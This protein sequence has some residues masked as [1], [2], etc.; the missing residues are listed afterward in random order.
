MDEKLLN[1]LETTYRDLETRQ[2]EAVALDAQGNQGETRRRVLAELNGPL[3]K[4]ADELC[5]RIAAAANEHVEENSAH[6]ARRVHQTAWVV[7]VSGGLT[8]GLGGALLWLFF[9]R[10]MIPLRGLVGDVQLLYGGAVPSQDHSEEDE[11]RMVGTCF[12]GLMSDVTDTRSSLERS[13]SRLL[14]AEKLASVGKLAASVA[15][16]IRNPLTAMKMWLFSIQESVRGNPELDHKLGIISEET[17]RL[18]HI[19]RDFLEFARPPPFAVRNSA[20]PDNPADVGTPRC[21]LKREE[22]FRGERAHGRSASR[23]G[24]PGPAQT[25]VDQRD[26]QC[27]GRDEHRR[28]D[29]HLDDGG[30]GRGGPLHGRG[31]DLRLGAGMAQAV[32]RRVFEPFFSTK[33]S[34]TGLGL[35]IA[36]RIMAAHNGL[37]VLESSSGKGTTFAI[38]TPVAQAGTH[39]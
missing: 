25:S 11:M 31:A 8:L 9:R 23:N 5:V 21:L 13:H 1:R 24:R 37:L 26:E 12:R 38:W 14:V 16:E 10:V 29:P 20:G 6:A 22:H 17:T 15:H 39:G 35:C 7:G 19:I 36:A 28:R 3:F 34:G 32:Q 30:E 2:H 27:G 33:E 4:E 18:D